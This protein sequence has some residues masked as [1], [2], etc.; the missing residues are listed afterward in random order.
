MPLW[1]FGASPDD[2]NSVAVVNY[3]NSLVSQNLSAT[4]VKQ[5][6]KNRFSLSTYASG[7]WADAI[8]NSTV[9]G[10]AFARQSELT[11][12]LSAKIPIL[13]NNSSGVPLKSRANGPVALDSTGKVDPSLIT[14]ASAQTFPVLSWS[15]SSYPTLSGV[16]TEQTICSIPVSSSLSS[17][18]VFVTG[19]I[20]AKI[21]PGTFNSADGQYA[22]I[23]VRAGNAITGQIV[24][25]GYGLAESY[26]GGVLTPI[27]TA[28]NY[29]YQVPSWCNKIDIVLVGAGGGGI[30]DSLGLTGAG[31]AGG[32][33]AAA[34]LTRGVNF[35]NSVVSISGVVGKG[36]DPENFN[37]FGYNN[38]GGGATTCFPTGIAGVAA[39]GGATGGGAHGSPTQGGSPGNYLYA[40]NTYVGGPAQTTAGGAGNSPG[41]GGAGGNR[42]PGGVGANG[43]AFFYA[44]TN[45]DINYGQI[46]VIPT[47]TS[48]SFTGSTTLYVNILREQ[49]GNTVSSSITT[50]SLNPQI[51]VMVVPV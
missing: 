12:G 15:P 1:Y 2:N 11:V 42:S 46:N 5:S 47:S 6:I 38:R 43:A 34:T 51:S 20:S 44:Y 7:S 50:S 23:Q 30:N 9:S 28:G 29:T 19:T 37:I 18:R 4:D 49:N 31:G 24:A 16:T 14:K 45:D 33:W 25:T 40:G 10:E 22:K 39:A 41:G 17:Y 13:G 48:G 32:S 26:R 35:S 36:G 8:V 27:T 21:V 3:V